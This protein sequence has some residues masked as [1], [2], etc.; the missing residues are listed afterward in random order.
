MSAKKQKMGLRRCRCAEERSSSST[1]RTVGSVTCLRHPLC[2]RAIKGV[3]WRSSLFL[4]KKVLARKQILQNLW[5]CKIT[6][7]WILLL[8]SVLEQWWKIS[9]IFEILLHYEIYRTK[10]KNTA[11]LKCSRKSH[12][13]S[14]IFFHIFSTEPKAQ[15]FRQQRPSRRRLRSL[16]SQQPSQ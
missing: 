15:E 12:V 8:I 1:D 10:I 16:L 5:P 13:K 14:I 11:L 9:S 6:L 2:T 7:I 4:Y 3:D